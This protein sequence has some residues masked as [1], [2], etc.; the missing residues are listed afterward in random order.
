MWRGPECLERLYAIAG[1]GCTFRGERAGEHGKRGFVCLR[2]GRRGGDGAIFAR[3]M[4]VRIWNGDGCG[5]VIFGVFIM[6]TAGGAGGYLGKDR[7]VEG[8]QGG[9]GGGVEGSDDGRAGE[10]VGVG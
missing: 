2:D 3:V 4:V 10:D 8:G 9:R 5:V 1:F 6:A 7:S